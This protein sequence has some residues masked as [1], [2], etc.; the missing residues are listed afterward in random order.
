MYILFEGVDTCG[1]TTQIELL[2]EKLDNIVTTK[3]PGG[4]STGSKIRSL[5]LDGKIH[6]KQAEILLFLADRAE[7]F[8]Q[9]IKPNQDKLIISDRGLISG[10]A[11]ALSN[12]KNV[13][14]DFLVK[15][16]LFSLENTL[17]N[18][19][20]LFQ[21]NEKL[22]KQRLS[23]KSH[24]TIEQRGIKYLLDVQ[25]NMEIVTK[26]LGIDY[27]AIDASKSIKDIHTQISSRL[28]ALSS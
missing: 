22:L 10:L 19:V 16:N 18:F 17:P 6:S 28:Q 7:H 14:L 11:Y 24:D 2:K 5:V 13:D 9:V 1:K 21:T 20:F 15:L 3:E 26:K 25:N 8:K 27:Q 4:T 23:R 12:D